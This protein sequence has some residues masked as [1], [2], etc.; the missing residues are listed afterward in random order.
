[1]S[2]TEVTAALADPDPGNAIAAEVNRLSKGYAENFCAYVERLGDIPNTILHVKPRTPI[3][4]VAMSL[5]TDAIQ[6][7]LT[8]DDA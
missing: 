1:L 8:G 5:T 3:E 6:Q 7:A 4:A 2:G